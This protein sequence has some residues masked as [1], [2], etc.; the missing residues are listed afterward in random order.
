[1]NEK[2]KTKQ[3]LDLI[4]PLCDKEAEFERAYGFGGINT[5]ELFRCEWC[6]AKIERH[7]R[8]DGT[9]SRIEVGRADPL[10]SEG[11]MDEVYR[12]HKDGDGWVIRRHHLNGFEG[13]AFGKRRA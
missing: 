4:C 5:R 13:V 11:K 3:K 10:W 12:H 6:Q 2:E 9:I 1:M 8:E 7:C